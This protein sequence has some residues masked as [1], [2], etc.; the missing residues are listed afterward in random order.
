MHAERALLHATGDLSVCSVVA[1]Q[2]QRADG[3][4]A[5]KLFVELQHMRFLLQEAREHAEILAARLERVEPRRRR[6]YTPPLRFRI[7]Q[8]MNRYMLSVEETARCFLV[9]PQTIYNWIAEM[10]PNPDAIRV[11]SRI[12]AVP[13]VRRYST[14][15]RRL[16]Q[17]SGPLH[18]TQEFHCT[19]TAVCGLWAARWGSLARRAP[20]PSAT[21]TS[22]GAINHPRGPGGAP[23]GGKSA[24]ALGGA[25]V[26]AARSTA[27]TGAGPS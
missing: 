25:A 6:H 21:P 17:R 4:T 24:A 7:L 3:T 26:S 12:V 8:H 22:Q 13:P 10:R 1:W 15:V 20:T 11:G 23:R 5:E 16:V 27:E 19:P 14:A 2:R 18:G 9:T